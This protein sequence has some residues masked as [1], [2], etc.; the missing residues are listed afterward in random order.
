[1]RRSWGAMPSS[2]LGHGCE[3]GLLP[4][5]CPELYER[6]R[7][8]FKK[9]IPLCKLVA[10]AGWEPVTRAISN[11]ENVRIERFGDQYLT[12]FNDSNQQQRV[13]IT[14]EMG[15]QGPTEELVSGRSLDRRNRSTV[16][17]VEAEDVAVLS[18]NRAS[19]Q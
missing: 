13:T 11:N 1:M 15:L 19:A 12:I 6:D 4:D 17:T 14:T 18:F 16:L 8:L 5:T 2:T 10:E 3:A 9:Y 7:D